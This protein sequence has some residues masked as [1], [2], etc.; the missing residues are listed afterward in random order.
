MQLWVLCPIIDRDAGRVEEWAAAVRRAAP[1]GATLYVAA[2]Q[3][4]FR[5][6]GS[7]LG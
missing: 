4:A 3:I 2:R 7:C 6:G 1:G 5:V